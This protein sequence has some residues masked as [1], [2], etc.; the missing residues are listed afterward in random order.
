M[1]KQ[2]R[3]QQKVCVAIVLSM[4]AVSIMA[5]SYAVEP[6]TKNVL[7]NAAIGAGAGAILGGVSKEGSAV[8]GAG[9]GALSGAGTGLINNSRTL[10]S[11]PVVKDT[12]KGAAIGAGTSAALGKNSLKGAGIGAGTGAL[13]GWF[14]KDSN[15]P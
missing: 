11:R 13:W 15:N 14:R 10:N 9:Y 5:S 7:R 6:A 3:F 12:L 2:P 4:V 8:R 1:T